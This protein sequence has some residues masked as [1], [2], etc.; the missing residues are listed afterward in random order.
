MIKLGERPASEGGN[1]A[2]DEYF[3]TRP[4]TGRACE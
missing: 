4:T 2:E 1:E 3:A